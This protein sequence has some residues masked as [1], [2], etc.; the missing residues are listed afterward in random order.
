M[1]SLDNYKIPTVYT[2]IADH[3]LD[4]EFD[5]NPLKT[6]EDLHKVDQRIRAKLLPI[7][8]VYDAVSWHGY[9]C[10]WYMQYIMAV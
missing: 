7:Q 1:P 9:I 6:D 5:L 10:G 8:V 3:L 2:P 4:V